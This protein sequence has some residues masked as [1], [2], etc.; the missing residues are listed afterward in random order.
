MLKRWV[1]QLSPWLSMWLGASFTKTSGFLNLC[2]SENLKKLHFALKMWNVSGFHAYS[3][4]MFDFTLNLVHLHFFHVKSVGLL[5][6]LNICIAKFCSAIAVLLSLCV[7]LPLWI[8]QAKRDFWWAFHCPATQTQMRQRP[9]NF[10]LSIYWRQS[11]TCGTAMWLTP[12]CTTQLIKNCL[13]IHRPHGTGALVRAPS[14]GLRRKTSVAVTP[15]AQCKYILT[16]Q[17][18]LIYYLLLLYVLYFPVLHF[19]VCM[20][21]C[22]C[23]PMSMSVST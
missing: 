8:K 4:G 14:G 22:L 5:V 16:T 20:S 6:H 9:L 11:Y 17:I 12:T 13:A 23:R 2:M 1:Q 21:Y 15:I 10:D 19:N 3:C 18:P 7:A